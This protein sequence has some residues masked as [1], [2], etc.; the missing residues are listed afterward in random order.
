MLSVYVDTSSAAGI[1]PHLLEYAVE[2][3]GAEKILFGTVR[4][5]ACASHP[6]LR[7]SDQEVEVNRRTHRC[8][9]QRCRGRASTAPSCRTRRSSSSCAATQS[10]SSPAAASPSTAH[11]SKERRRPLLLRPFWTVTKPAHCLLVP[12]AGFLAS[13]RRKQRKNGEKSVKNGRETAI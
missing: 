10:G 7:P 8:T 13:R 1:Q 9:S 5:F 3:I 4:A 12:L 6:C 11:S 2:K